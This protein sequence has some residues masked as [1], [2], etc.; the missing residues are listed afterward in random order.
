MFVHHCHNTKVADVSH[1]I[2]CV[3]WYLGLDCLLVSYHIRVVAGTEYK[4]H[5]VNSLSGTPN[6]GVCYMCNNLK[7]GIVNLAQMFV[8]L[9][10]TCIKYGGQEGSTAKVAA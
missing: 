7:H 9:Q 5:Q 6:L 3:H 8:G 1:L 4:T 10:N 2:L